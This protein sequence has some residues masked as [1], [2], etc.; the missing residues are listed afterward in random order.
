VPSLKSE[1]EIVS[2]QSGDN[3][4]VQVGSLRVRADA[5]TLEWRSGKKK[6]QEEPEYVA[7]PRSLSMESPGLELHLRG[8]MVED[9][10][11]MVDEYL[12]SAFLSGLPWVHIVHGRGTGAL[13]K[14]I[15]D[16][17]RQHP[18]VKEYAKAPENQGGDGVTVVK[19][20]PH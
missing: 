18:L 9:A 1:G 5:D 11:P 17:L 4:E 7:N 15:R 6:A 13:R 12:D 14:A 3:V 16:H 10:I 19:F 2:I 8:F 20:V